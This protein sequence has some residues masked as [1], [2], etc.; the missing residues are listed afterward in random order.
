M[1]SNNNMI[2]ELGNVIV[3]DAFNYYENKYVK[4]R[5]IE[6]YLKYY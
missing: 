2:T 6:N 1:L 4:N 3:Q 5:L